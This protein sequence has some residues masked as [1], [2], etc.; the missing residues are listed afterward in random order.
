VF[1]TPSGLPT[2]S[3]NTVDGKVAKGWS[4]NAVFSEILS[5]QLEYKYLS[6][7]TGRK[8]YY[9]A[10]ENVMDI[11]YEANMTSTGELFLSMWS[12]LDGSPIGRMSRT[13]SDLA[14]LVADAVFRN[15]D[16]WRIC[17][18]WV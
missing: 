1:L 13:F 8:E 18:Q 16:R 10:V 2:F 14:S 11:M 4:E 12:R 3:V 7:L 5:C 6:S 15:G 17:R 9:D